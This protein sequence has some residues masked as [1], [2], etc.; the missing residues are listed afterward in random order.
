[1]L[2]KTLSLAGSA[3]KGTEHTPLQQ[4]YEK[5]LWGRLSIDDCLG[6]FLELE[7]VHSFQSIN[8]PFLISIYSI[9]YLLW[10]VNSGEHIWTY[11]LTLLQTSA[12][13]SSTHM[14]LSLGK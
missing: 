3:V 6:F 13:R 10:Y 11:R 2:N 1:M 4:K 5:F 8:T 9:T 12:K 14:Y 7:G